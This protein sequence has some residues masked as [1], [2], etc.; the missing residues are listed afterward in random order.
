[1]SGRVADGRLI[2]G[3]PPRVHLL[4]PEIEGQRKERA[5]RGRLAAVLAGSVLLV[6]VAVG[7]VS[8]LLAVSLSQQSAEQSQGLLLAQQLK[9]YIG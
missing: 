5:F 8:L 4:P 9:K 6:I 1:M 2:L 3:G 7:V